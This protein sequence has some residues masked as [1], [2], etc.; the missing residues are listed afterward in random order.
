MKE[1][2]KLVFTEPLMPVLKIMDWEQIET[3]ACG[4]KTVDIDKLKGISYYSGASADSAIVKRFWKVLTKFDDDQ[5]QMYLKFV[6]G[7]SRLPSDLKGLCYKHGVNVCR[8][9][10][11]ESLP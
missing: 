2:I 11:K 10:G 7:R 1:G 6:W 5:R 9:M 4:Q 8:H 3:R